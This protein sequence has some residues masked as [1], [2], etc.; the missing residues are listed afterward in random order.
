MLDLFIYF[1]TTIR[2]SPISWHTSL[3]EFNDEKAWKEKWRR[4]TNSTTIDKLSPRLRCYISWWSA[5]TRSM[6][7]IVF[8]FIWEDTGKE[9]EVTNRKQDVDNES[10]KNTS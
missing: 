4:K 5:N 2:E 10:D 6:Q 1:I 8:D 9:V 7:R 3:P